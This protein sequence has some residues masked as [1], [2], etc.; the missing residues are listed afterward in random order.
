MMY[1]EDLISYYLR[2]K[3]KHQNDSIKHD[4]NEQIKV[5]LFE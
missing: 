3:E 2:E 1:C 5:D 4:S